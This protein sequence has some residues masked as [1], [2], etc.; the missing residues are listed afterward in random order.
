MRGKRMK[1]VALVLWES[2]KVLV[3]EPLCIWWTFR[4]SKRSLGE[5]DATFSWVATIGKCCCY[6]ATLNSYGCSFSN[7]SK[8]R[9]VF[10]EFWRLKHFDC[11]FVCRSLS[12]INVFPTKRWSES[13]IISL[14][15]F[16]HVISH[17]RNVLEIKRFISVK[18][19]WS[20]LY[21]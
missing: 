15:R 20:C 7:K 1:L 14:W 6:T 17:Q 8:A 5:I 21:V 19:C 3:S 10:M 9:G 2:S 4:R 18:V 12:L 16:L 11:G 13:S